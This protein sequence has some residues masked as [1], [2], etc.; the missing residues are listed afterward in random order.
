MH[1]V[2]Q[3]APFQKWY[4]PL[5]LSVPASCLSNGIWSHFISFFRNIPI[6]HLNCSHFR[7]LW[8]A[9]TCVWIHTGAEEHIAQV[10]CLYARSEHTAQSSVVLIPS[11][12]LSRITRVHSFPWGTWRTL[13][14]RHFCSCPLVEVSSDH[15]LKPP[16]SH[17]VLYILWYTSSEG[18]LGM[19]HLYG[20]TNS[21]MA[22]WDLNIFVVLYL[23]SR[24]SLLFLYSVAKYFQSGEP[25]PPPGQ[26]PLSEVFLHFAVR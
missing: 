20:L 13:H 12:C 11:S 4:P 8:C 3:E 6:L 23:N 9:C 25:V 26:C 22:F 1:N 18:L 7:T 10:L 16:C 21:L 2:H 24:L 15:P 17:F 5:L 14:K 19:P